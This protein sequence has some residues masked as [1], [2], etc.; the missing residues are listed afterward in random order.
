MGVFDYHGF[1]SVQAWESYD[2]YLEDGGRYIKAGR[3]RRRS[4]TWVNIVL[5]KDFYHSWFNFKSIIHTTDKAYLLEVD[6][7]KYGMLEIWVPKKLI[8]KME[9]GRIMVHTSIFIDICKKKY[10]ELQ[11]IELWK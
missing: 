7:G 5:D 10:S 6:A 8:R 9:D 2:S 4:S 11:E 1:Y 3:R